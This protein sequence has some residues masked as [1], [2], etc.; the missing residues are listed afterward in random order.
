M[1]FR[2]YFLAFIAAVLA[3][4][5]PSINTPPSLV[6]CQPT[7]LTWN[8]TNTPVY[9]SV[10]PGGNASAPALMDLGRQ[11]GTSMT[12]SVNITAGA[13]ITLR[14]V[15]SNGA[16]AYSALIVAVLAQADPSIN[17]PASL[18]QCQPVQITWNASKQP[19]SLRCAINVLPI[20]GGQI[21]TAPFVEFAQ[22][23]GNSYTWVVNVH[24]GTSV[25]LRLQ[26]SQGVFAYSGPSQTT[27][28]RGETVIATIQWNLVK[29]SNISMNDKTSA[30]DEVFPRSG[31]LSMSRV[32]TTTTGEQLKWKDS[33]KLYCFSVETGLNLA[34]YD[35]TYFSLFR[36]KKSTL[37]I[38]ADGT[39]LTDD[40]IITWVIAEKKAR[41]RRRSQ[42]VG[43]GGGS[44]G[45][46]SQTEA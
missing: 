35:R 34:T 31:A 21:G 12:W 19:I 40:L 8:A 38:S 15:D 44:G 41:N 2:V 29:G 39:H 9:I 17:T 30:I 16:N 10:I 6:Q 5:D 1:L 3:Q 27:I 26:D 32:W 28:K 11:S 37:D 4:A 23:Q 42:S 24:Q 45:G 22:L 25:T 18:V 43:R 20:N 7:Q 46:V 14:I 36:D 33:V 13:S